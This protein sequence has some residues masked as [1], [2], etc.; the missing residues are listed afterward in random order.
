[1]ASRRTVDVVQMHPEIHAEIT[2]QRQAA[3]LAE[4][5]VS[6]AGRTLRGEKGTSSWL[7]RLAAL[8]R[9]R[10]SAQSRPA[11]PQKPSLTTID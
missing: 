1:V 7:V 8:A 5:R 9:R 4:A 11:S 10:P 6:R 3:L 2:R